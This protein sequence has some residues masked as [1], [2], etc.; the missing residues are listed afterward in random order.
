MQ[1]KAIPSMLS[2]V[3]SLFRGVGLDD[4]ER[5]KAITRNAYP[6]FPQLGTH[7]LASWMEE[8]DTAPLLIDVRSGAEFDVSHLQGA[9]NLSS[10]EAIAGRLRHPKPQRVVLY[11]SVGFRSSRIASLLAAQG[12]D[13]IL[14]LEGSIFQW[15]NEGR[16]VF[17]GPQR[18]HQ[19]HPYGPRWAGLLKPGL[20]AGC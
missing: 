16:P 17:R 12:L 5:I 8:A 19:V 1:P 3:P 7:E 11:C 9:V 10:V 6:S 15:A 14:N 4:L 18:V 20:A 2:M 13:G